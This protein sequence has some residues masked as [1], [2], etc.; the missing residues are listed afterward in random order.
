M[1]IKRDPDVSCVVPENFTE[2]QIAKAKE[3]LHHPDRLLGRISAHASHELGIH[4]DKGDPKVAREV[5]KMTFEAMF[6]SRPKE[7]QRPTKV[8]ARGSG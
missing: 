2:E 7:P 3:K 4:F 8:R 6:L 1:T 5:M